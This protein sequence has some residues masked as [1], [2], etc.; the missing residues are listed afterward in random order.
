M[1]KAMENR[2][3]EILKKGF[4]PQ[5]GL[6]IMNLDDYEANNPLTVGFPSPTGVKYYECKYERL[7]SQMN[8]FR[9]QQ[10]LSIMNGEIQ[11]AMNVISS[12]FRPQQ[13]LSIMNSKKGITFVKVNGTQ[14]SVPN[15]G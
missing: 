14:V 13:G 7:W 2:K 12:R 1:N 10:G 15:R 3:L 11:N 8:R 9:P 5:Q 6:S 4:R